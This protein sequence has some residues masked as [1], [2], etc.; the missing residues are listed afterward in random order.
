MFG[1]QANEALR[2]YPA[3]NDQ[4][5][6]H[7]A[8]EL[9]GDLFMGYRTC[10]WCDLHSK[11]GGAPVYRYLYAHP[12][13]PM[14][15]DMG[16][17]VPGLAGGVIK[18]SSQEAVVPPPA[19]GAVHSAEIEYAMGN[20]ATNLVYAWTP[21]DYAVSEVM[22]SFFANLV[23]TGDPNGPDLPAWPAA[24]Q[25]DSV[26]VMRIDSASRAEPEQHRARYEFLDS[27]YT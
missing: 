20:L 24:N 15:P 7:S 26:Q 19:R 11:T 27:L 5:V 17:V 10:K 4:E 9:A 8:T 25:G 18:R 14:N 2:L 13:P 3:E 22:Q 6:P 16:D 23:K 12:R 21:E 1:D